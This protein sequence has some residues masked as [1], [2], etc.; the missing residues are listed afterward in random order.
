[1]VEARAW[2]LPG[3]LLTVSEDH[4]ASRRTIEKNGG[5]LLGSAA[6]GDD[7]ELA[8]WLPVPVAD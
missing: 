1:L 6:D 4:T 7:L 8:Y 5:I 2:K 3:L